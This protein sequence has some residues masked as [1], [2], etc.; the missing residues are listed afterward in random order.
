LGFQPDSA[1]QYASIVGR[2]ANEFARISPERRR[3]QHS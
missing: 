3:W 1:G 2:P